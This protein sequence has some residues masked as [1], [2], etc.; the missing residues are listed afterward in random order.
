MERDLEHYYTNFKRPPFA[1]TY[2]PTE[3][4]FTDP[5]SYVAQ[6]KPEAE[7]YGLI[8]IV[9]PKNF[10]PPFCIDSDKFE[11]T[12]RIQR[13]N[14]IDALFRLR[15]IFINKLV[16]FWQI[17]GQQFRIPYI[18]NKYIDLYR[19]AQ[20]VT[21]KGGFEQIN[22]LR[23][24]SQIARTL[25]FRPNAGPSLKNHYLKWIYPFELSASH[26]INDRKSSSN[27]STQ[28]HEVIIGKN[29]LSQTG[30]RMMAGLN[31]MKPIPSLDKSSTQKN[32]RTPIELVVCAKC[33]N[34]D[35]E[36]LLML[37]ETCD[38]SMH[39]YC[40]VPPLSSVP[41]GEW[42][43]Q[44]C[45]AR[46][47]KRVSMDFGFVDSNQRYNL[48]TFGEWA[49]NFKE[50]YFKQAPCDVLCD[51]VEAEFWRNVIDIDKEI[52]V[53]YGADL[54]ASKVGSG[55][56]TKGDNCRTVDTKERQHYANHPWNLNN[57]PKLRES[58]LCHMTTDISGMMV[59][60]VYIG[61]VFST[62]CWHVEDHWTYSIN[63][64]HWGER[65]IWYGI[66]GDQAD[67]FECVMKECAPEL[68]RE[69]NDLLH[70][71]TTSLNPRYLIDRGVPV[72]TVH[73][74]AGEFVITFPRSYHAGYNEGLN[75]A[76]AVNFAPPDWLRMGRLCLEDYA[77]V[78]RDCV[79]SHDELVMK[80]VSVSTKM[81]ISM[82]LATLEELS[83][84]VT[85][86]TE[87]RKRLSLA[88]L[89][90]SQ[91]CKFE[92]ISD[93]DR[94]CIVCRTTLFCSGL[95]CQ[96]K[97]RMVCMQHIDFLCNKCKVSDSCLK[98][99]YTLEDLIPLVKRLTER[100]N[101]F[102]EWKKNVNEICSIATEVSDNI[103][104]KQT[105]LN[106]TAEKRKIGMQKVHL[107][108]DQ[109]KNLRFPHCNE[110]DQINKI[111]S[112]FEQI[113]LAINPI[114]NRKIRLRDKTRC[115]KADIRYQYA[116]V[117][118]LRQQLAESIYKDVDLENGLEE[119]CNK[120]ENWKQRM[121]TAIEGKFLGLSSIDTLHQLINEA[122]EEFNV[123]F[124]TDDLDLLKSQLARFQWLVKAEHLIERIEEI[125]KG[126]NHIQTD[127]NIQK[128]GNYCQEKKFFDLQ[129]LEKL[130]SESA[131]WRSTCT[132]VAS[133]EI[134]LKNIF[135]SA[136]IADVAASNFLSN[137]ESV[138]YE[139]SE[140]FWRDQLAGTAW[141]ESTSMSNFRT[142]LQLAQQ[143]QINFLFIT[144]QASTLYRL[145][146]LN[147][148]CNN[149]LF[150]R[151]G[152]RHNRVQ[153]MLNSV[154]AFV[155]RINTIFQKTFNYY[156]L[157]DI[158]AGRSDL[159]ILIEGDPIPLTLFS[160]TKY[161]ENWSQ[162]YNFDSI[163]LLSAHLN[164]ITEQQS[165]L[166]HALR[167]AN[168]ERPLRE[169]CSCA[170]D[171]YT[172]TT[173]SIEKNDANTHIREENR[174]N[175]Y[176]CNAKFHEPC[177]QWDPFF[178]RL[179]PGIFLCPRC[180]R[181]RRPCVEDVE[182]ACSNPTV[183]DN[184][185][186]KLVVQNLVTKS[187]KI[188]SKLHDLLNESTKNIAEETSNEKLSTV[189]EYIIL[190]LSLE[191]VD[192]EIYGM[193]T[194]SIHSKFFSIPKE[195]IAIWQRIRERMVDAE[196]KHIIFSVLYPTNP[197]VSQSNIGNS[198][199]S[200][201]GIKRRKSLVSSGRRKSTRKSLATKES[202]QKNEDEKLI[203]SEGN[204]ADMEDL[205]DNCA[206]DDLKD[207]NAKKPSSIEIQERCAA[208]FCLKPYSEYTRWI[209]CEAGC[210]RWYHFCCV[211]IS[212]RRAQQISSYCC[213]KCASSSKA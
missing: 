114:L 138:G 25:G 96:H 82:C 160:S 27:E 211:G 14:E 175:C 3:K 94:A 137:A 85:R 179:I 126:N 108:A 49:N 183:P 154:T 164:A 70:H 204:N 170:S 58:V 11:F 173:N 92:E 182:A 6:I 28:Q 110:I 57:L 23:Q 42:R 120:V 193:F 202:D 162:L 159:P 18:D 74:N 62:F 73:Q 55:F 52:Q 199:R 48:N 195:H 50:H 76:E 91:F 7:K 60:W 101:S 212:V 83:W 34:G 119:I 192:T 132:H 53:R 209:Q 158:I 69:Q 171:Q 36:A 121:R 12:P 208:D 123:R 201:T 109:W 140:M 66:S 72:Y 172:S 9:P 128:D 124:E 16:K 186:E 100:T 1:P 144:E 41:K 24:W 167:L 142:E 153:E 71:M 21:E 113:S 131:K 31:K 133:T 39:T 56:P 189:K 5:I 157:F 64:N 174:I 97:G 125:R 35:D 68:F 178:T 63:Y 65:K 86:E 146:Q 38:N 78:G 90:E 19:L 2:Y 134:K 103:K 200:I 196:P 20:L 17:H 152:K 122:E 98:F 184:L 136:M 45:L 165:T 149:S 77:A 44:K 51:K 40:V 163:E 43:C 194:S 197:Y 191:V 130:L 117:L 8:K 151:N 33:G 95:V 10:R 181:S 205:K 145:R 99:R 135:D 15:I 89:R 155:E 88:G 80:M 46:V 111:L 169:T 210:T 213:Y 127:F 176:I 148:H 206:T 198:G 93:D 26:D 188:Y 104:N 105:S 187:V 180:L 30:N 190:T 87:F 61:M 13:L 156:N 102:Y 150:E 116:Q 139:N 177:A 81:S 67:N 32:H 118:Q 54:M 112:D 4:E 107:L 129:R 141:L 84:I 59:P 168:E 106:N 203:K 185:L 79:F 161:S 22:E 143:I 207:V 166:L 29:N 37:C 147:K 115:Q 75:C 47:L